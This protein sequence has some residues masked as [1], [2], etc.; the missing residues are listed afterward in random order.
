[1]VRLSLVVVVTV[2]CARISLADPPKTE[3]LIHTAVAE[4][5]KMQDSDGAW[6]YEG[7]YRVA[8]EIPIGYRVGG[9]A[10]V[11]ETL[12]YAAK[13]DD[14]TRTSIERGVQYILSKLDDPLLKPSTEDTYDVR[15]WGHCCVLQTFCRLRERNLLGDHATDIQRWVPKL[16]EALLLEQLSD[17]GWNYANRKAHAGFVT[18]PVAQALLLARSQGEKV[19][20]QVLEKSRKAL[21]GSRYADGAFTYSGKSRTPRVAA[22][23]QPAT[24]SAPTAS[25]KASDGPTSASAP[26]T[27]IAAMANAG[28]PRTDQL[29]GSIARSAACES[30]L[31]LLGD[32]SQRRIADALDAFHRY[33]QELENRRKK[34]GTHLGPYGI[35]PYYFY[36]GH[37]YAAQGIQLLPVEAREKERS[38]LLEVILRTRDEDGT[39]NDRVFPRSRNFGTA[40]IVL[41]LLGDAAPLPPKYETKH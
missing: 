7:V 15:V 12:L 40:M 41:A 31:L 11:I 5:L 32:G 8:G 2:L 23:S 21:L 20:D 3:E 38:R 30:T 14:D 18:A 33:W 25:S 22:A 36:Y 6:P 19:P 29:P 9:T 35:A 26:A 10:I 24:G 4:L 27:S 37:R 39:W 1:M 17:G 13:L 16:V 34:T 28:V